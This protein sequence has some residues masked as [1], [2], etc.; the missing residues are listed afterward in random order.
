MSQENLS[1]KE[2]IAKMSKEE[3]DINP[4]EF[5]NL[6]L[7]DTPIGEISREDKEYLN[8]FENL[9]RLAMNATGIKNLNNLPDKLKIVRV[10][11]YL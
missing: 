10:S 4:K 8:N 7:D 11:A 1:L 9:E 6:I 3:G 5:S 2:R